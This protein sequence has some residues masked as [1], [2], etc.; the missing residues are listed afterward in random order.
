MA[1]IKGKNTK[2]EVRLAK[3]LWHRGHRYRKHDRSI[4][5]TPDLS[6]KKYR[7]AVFVDG[8]FFHG[9]EWDTKQ[10]PQT[11]VAFWEQ[12]IERN[13]SRDNEV[14]AYLETHGWIVIRF[15]SKDVQKKLYTS[16]RA[17]EARIEEV[18]KRIYYK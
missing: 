13:I 12:K 16:V 3:A 7:I 15:W 18:K 6:F 17:I 11:N 5:G 14:N 1:S 10:R 9:K 8:E 4:Y 2:D